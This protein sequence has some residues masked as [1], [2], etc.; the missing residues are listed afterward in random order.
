MQFVNCQ[1][2]FV[3]RWQLLT[4]RILNPEGRILMAGLIELVDG[5][6]ASQREVAAAMK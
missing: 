3:F 2:R 1:M 4:I 5:T 6:R